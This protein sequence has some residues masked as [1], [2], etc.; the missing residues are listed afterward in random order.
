MT[1]GR[2]IHLFTDFCG[3]LGK[4]GFS[5][6]GNNAE[7]IFSLSACFGED[8]AWH[9]GDRERDPW[10]WRMRVLEETDWIAY[11]KLFFNKSGYLTREWAP[12]FLAV[13]RKGEHAGEAYRD[14]TLSEAAMRI[15]DLVEEHTSLPVHLIKSYGGFIGEGAV[16]FDRALTELQMRMFLTMCG[17]RRKTSVK[18]EEYGWNSTVFC[19]TDAFYGSAVLEKADRTSLQEAREAIATQVRRLNPEADE[20]KIKK[21]ISG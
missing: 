14:G 7:G 11:A 8:I 18:G 12:Y 2:Q 5:M 21:F 1:Q 17:R 13:R 19:T 10:E 16:G 6:G 15:H 20:R 3:E 9:T 4:A